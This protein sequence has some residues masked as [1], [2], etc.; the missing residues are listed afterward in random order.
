M[1]LWVNQSGVS[2]SSA[3]LPIG[4]AVELTSF[5][6]QKEDEHVSGAEVL[7]CQIAFFSTYRTVQTL[8]AVTCRGTKRRGAFTERHRQDE[9]FQTADAFLDGAT[10]RRLEDMSGCQDNNPG[11]YY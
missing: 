8:V 7:D 3:T 4:E 2:F 11:F 1:E 6:A 5:G 10:C 9:T